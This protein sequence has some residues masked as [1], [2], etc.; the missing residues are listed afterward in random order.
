MIPNQIKIKPLI[1][2]AALIA[3]GI[4]FL[5]G[6]SF[7]GYNLQDVILS[8]IFMGVCMLLFSYTLLSGTPTSAIMTTGLKSL[9]QL[10][11]Q[12]WETFV[13][14]WIIILT[15]A[16]LWI[17]IAGI[18]RGHWSRPRNERG[19]IGASTVVLIGLNAFL[20]KIFNFF[21]LLNFITSTT[22]ILLG[23]C[24]IAF[25]ANL[26]RHPLRT[27]PKPAERIVM[28]RQKA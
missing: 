6:P 28:N 4:L 18:H 2:G 21:G 20:A 25:G 27:N 8:C 23:A 24:L 26:R 11:C 15:A 13:Y 17:F 1:G 19:L 22:L 3:S 16:A 10:I 12:H 5:I 14:G 9:Y 7:E